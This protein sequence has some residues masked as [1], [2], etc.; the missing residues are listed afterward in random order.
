MVIGNLS[1]KVREDIGEF[2]SPIDI[3]AQVAQ[4]K[5]RI[6]FELPRKPESSCFTY[7]NACSPVFSN[8]GMS[9]KDSAV[10]NFLLVS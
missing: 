9:L 2:T 1:T 8:P 7:K 10:V 4:A 6:R 3:A 5:V